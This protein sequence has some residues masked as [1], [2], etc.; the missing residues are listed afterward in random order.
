MPATSSHWNLMSSHGVVLF[1]IAANPHSTMRE[2]SA[3][4]ELT[5]RRVSQI[6]R[7]LDDA[8]LLVVWK[9]GRR[10]H[11][12]VNHEACFRHPTL[13]HVQL[14]SFERVFMDTPRTPAVEDQAASENAPRA[15]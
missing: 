9:E 1:Y 12:S 6:I 5:E 10:N 3:K 4:L 8:A 13:S 2:M 15:G 7:D 14:G 11:Y